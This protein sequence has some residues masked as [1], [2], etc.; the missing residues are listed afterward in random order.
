MIE[1]PDRLCFPVEALEPLRI[2]A[3]ALGQDLDGDFAAETRIVGAIDLAHPSRTAGRMD[4]V[5]A[6]A[7]ARR[8]RHEAD[9]RVYALEGES[10]PE[11]EVTY[12]GNT[13]MRASSALAGRRQVRI[14]RM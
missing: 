7:S 9:A 2:R 1:G 11:L 12:P 10:Q 14:G 5:G 8:Q 3:G 6:E 13:M 4:S